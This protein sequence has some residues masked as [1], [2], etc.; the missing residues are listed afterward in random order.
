MDP[1]AEAP[2]AAAIPWDTLHASVWQA[3]LQQLPF[4]RR[5]RAAL[6]CT[7]WRRHV[8]P[9]CSQHMEL[10]LHRSR[11]CK[12]LGLWLWRYG[13]TL[14]SIDI[15][16][17]YYMHQPVQGATR[18][19]P[20]D[21]LALL[22]GLHGNGRPLAALRSLRLCLDELSP[23]DAAVL[24]LCCCPVLTLL[25]LDC[26]GS[27]I[28]VVG[29][30]GLA[31]LS[32]LQALIVPTQSLGDEGL[33]IICSSLR[34]LQHINLHNDG[35][36]TDDG[37]PVL[38]QL[39]CLT[40]LDLQGSISIT[41]RGMAVLAEAVQQ[42]QELNISWC[43]GVDDWGLGQLCALTSLTGL[44]L[45]ATDVQLRDETA[46]QQLSKLAKLAWLSLDR[47]DVGKA[48]LEALAAALP[49]LQDLSLSYNSGMASF[50]ELRALTR[51]SQL[52]RLDV[53]HPMGLQHPDVDI[54][55]VFELTQL[56]SLNACYVLPHGSGIQASDMY[57]GSSRL[58]WV[59]EVAAGG[60]NAAGASTAAAAAGGGTAAAG[61]TTAAATAA[62]SSTAADGA[63]TAAAAAGTSAAAGGAGQTLRWRL[64]I[65]DFWQQMHLNLSLMH[66]LTELNFLG[67]LSTPW[68]D[69]AP[70]PPPPPPRDPAEY[71]VA[72]LLPPVPPPPPPPPPPKPRRAEG[73]GVCQAAL[74]LDALASVHPQPRMQQLR[75][76]FLRPRELP[77]HD[78]Q[79]AAQVHVALLRHVARAL[80]AIKVWSAGL[81]A[82]A[83][84]RAVAAAVNSRESS[85]SSKEALG[86]DIVAAPATAAL[87]DGSGSREG[88]GAADAAVP[89]TAAEQDGNSS[90]SM[91]APNANSADAAAAATAVPRDGSSSSSTIASLHEIR[92]N[93]LLQMLVASSSKQLQQQWWWERLLLQRFHFPPVTSSPPGNVDPTVHIALDVT[94][95]EAAAMIKHMLPSLQLLQ[96][97]VAMAEDS[98][99]NVVR[100]PDGE[101][102]Q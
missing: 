72:D 48:Q 63:S 16:D 86:T 82:K 71:A 97:A 5:C 25:Q 76:S 20:E 39:S 7:S 14:V 94:P 17:S 54:P 34:Q 33:S 26:N 98:S 6:V 68:Q 12:G 30:Q 74:L 24:G 37:L 95:A 60:R 18:I 27:N 67:N 61:A 87:Q 1:D 46:L 8:L 41:N 22:Q 83:A 42:L 38:S 65:N 90:S 64:H 80:A 2:P 45:A 78:P 93:A 96:L 51:L 21:R 69:N 75:L 35:H 32:Q 29:A 15:T 62:A 36:V 99:D 31:P 44:N 88:A 3:V 85:S 10:T 11:S 58:G 52:T 102:Q 9:L 92:R 84:E 50:G 49:A 47:C 13:H 91:Q 66:N 70:P 40:S 101:T 77:L 23:T 55:A 53:S 57:H 73:A 59:Q 81:D 100:W 28:G 19:R 89:A 79:A 56:H 4:K 43:A